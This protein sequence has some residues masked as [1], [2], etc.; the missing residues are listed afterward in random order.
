MSLDKHARQVAPPVAAYPAQTLFQVL[1]TIFK[2]CLNFTS[3]VVLHGNLPAIHIHPASDEVV[4]VGVE[5]EISPCLVREAISESIVLQYTGTVRNCP[6]RETRQSTI[7]V[8]TC[9]AVEIASF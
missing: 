2:G 6:A 5:L 4:V 9:R 3:L 1:W 8:E 7:N